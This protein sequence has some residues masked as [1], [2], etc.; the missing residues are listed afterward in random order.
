MNVIFNEVSYLDQSKGKASWQV[1]NIVYS[2][3][4]SNKKTRI[5]SFGDGAAAFAAIRSLNPGD[6]IEVETKKNGDFINWIG[7]K[8]VEGG[9]APSKATVGASTARSTGTW[10]TPEERAKKQVY[11]IKQSCLAQAAAYSGLR[12]DGYPDLDEHLAIAQRFVDWVMEEP[13]LP[14]FS[15]MDDDINF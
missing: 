11:I 4:G 12:Q 3:N 7:V 5:M 14:P 13:K 8:K 2:E 9:T 15:D 6:A 10:E 1:A